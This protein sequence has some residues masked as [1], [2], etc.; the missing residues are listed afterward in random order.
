MNPC[1]PK[2]IFPCGNYPQAG[3]L[4]QTF[5][6][7]EGS[8]LLTWYALSTQITKTAMYSLWFCQWTYALLE[9]KLS[10]HFALHQL[11]LSS[12]KIILH[13]INKVI[14]ESEKDLSKMVSWQNLGI[15]KVFNSPLTTWYYHVGKEYK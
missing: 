1:R 14:P 4:V 5:L 12:Y 2:H 13:K 7:L 10:L 8:M 9:I 11:S 6:T 15:S 3:L